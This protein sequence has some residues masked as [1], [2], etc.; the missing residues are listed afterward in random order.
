[1][2]RIDTM[3]LAV[4]DL[5]SGVDPKMQRGLSTAVEIPTTTLEVVDLQYA[6]GDAILLEEVAVTFLPRHL[7]ALMGPSGAG[8]TTLM[9]VVSG[10]AGGEVLRG[11]V[12]VNGAAATPRKLRLLMSYMPQDDVLYPALT[13]RQTLRYATLLRCPEHWKASAKL[14]RAD[15]IAAKLGSRRRREIEGRP[16]T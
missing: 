15:D 14:A 10:R 12:L 2:G 7:T 11:A 5:E 1:M 6:V 4:K 9:N 13:V 8:K 3:S 16:S